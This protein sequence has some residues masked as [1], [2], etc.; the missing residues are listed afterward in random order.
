MLTNVH[1]AIRSQD[2][3]S[4]PHNAWCFPHYTADDPAGDYSDTEGT[5]EGAPGVRPAY[6][7]ASRSVVSVTF[8]AGSDSQ[9]TITQRTTQPF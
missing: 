5:G 6:S 1:H 7:D 8:I 4:P 2:R 3:P 9:R